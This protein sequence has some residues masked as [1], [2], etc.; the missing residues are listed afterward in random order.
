MFIFDWILEYLISKILYSYKPVCCVIVNIVMDTNNIVCEEEE[1][2]IKEDLINF[3]GKLYHYCI[4]LAHPEKIVRNPKIIDNILNLKENDKELKRFRENFYLYE[5]YS[6]YIQYIR[7][8]F[9]YEYKNSICAFIRR[10]LDIVLPNMNSL[11][12]DKDIE[13]EYSIVK[14]YNDIYAKEYRSEDITIGSFK[15]FDRLVTYN[16]LLRRL[17]KDSILK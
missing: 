4:Y 15:D 17:K 7:V 11:A 9:S 6:K 1:N 2:N 8:I 3:N 13:L 16:S 12:T 14:R 5:K 10:D